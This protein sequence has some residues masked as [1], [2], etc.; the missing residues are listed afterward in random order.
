MT[1][2]TGNVAVPDRRVAGHAPSPVKLAVGCSRT[3]APVEN[4]PSVEDAI[5]LAVRAHRGQ[6]YPSPEREPYIF[7]PLRVML[8]FA[9]APEQMAAV[10]H[11]AIEDSDL[12]SADL[13]RA[14]YPP[15]VIEAIECLSRCP[16]EE[17][18]D[19]I[20]RVATNEI[21]RRVKLVDLAENLANNR[22]CPDALGNAGRIIQY[23][24]ALVRLSARR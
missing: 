10:L 18:A 16:G 5:A 20:E 15:R 17:Y 9:H 3:L 23:E 22:R 12:T 13:V 24:A 2:C 21:A 4:I 1:V 19:Y 6:R 7:H 8:A 11:D 14:G